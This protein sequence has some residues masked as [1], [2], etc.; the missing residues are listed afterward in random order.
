M[1]NK[2]INFIFTEPEFKK[3][4]YKILLDFLQQYSRKEK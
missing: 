1:V 3:N 2:N 4:E